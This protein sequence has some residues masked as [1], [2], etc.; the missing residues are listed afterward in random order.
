MV[1]QPV[2]PQEILECGICRELL[3]DPVTLACCGRSFCRECLRALLL[4]N[5]DTG[6]VR[7]PAGCGQ[8]VPLRLPPRSYVL[9]RCL[10]AAAPEELARRQREAEEDNANAEP[11]PGGFQPWDEVAASDDLKVGR[12][13]VVSY[14]TP[15]VVL[16][17]SGTDRIEVIF[18]SRIDFQR[19]S[20]LVLPCE[21]LRQLPGHFGVKI[22]QT[23]VA[24]QDLYCHDTL[25]AHLG[26]RGVAYEMHSDDRIK[27]KFEHRAD[28]VDQGINVHYSEVRPYGKLLGGYEVGQRVVAAKDLFS[29]STLIVRARTQA[30]VLLEYSDSRLTVRFDER[31]DGNSHSVN[32][33]LPE[34]KPLRPSPRPGQAEL[35]TPT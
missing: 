25:L 15:G 1:P 18:D 17:P 27:V 8:V 31:A 11:L 30:V 5:S 6:V 3:L 22:G 34:I 2:L 10:E 19:R 4:S 16:G 13:V 23:V 21:L 35:E 33:L 29:G 14:A 26:T 24:V 28:G 12:D 7:C 32:V 9:Q 20:L